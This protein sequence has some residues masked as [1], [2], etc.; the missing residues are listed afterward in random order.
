MTLELSGLA[1]QVRAM[2]QQL[3]VREQEYADLVA[4]ARLWL[5]QY[6]DQGESLCHPARNFHAAI[7][8][9]E[10]L[11]AEHPLPTVPERFTFIAADGT[12]IQPDSHEL[13]YYYLINVGCLVYRH[14]SGQTPEAYSQPTIGYAEDDIYDRGQLVA[15]N[16]LD[17][18][19]DLAEI[20]TLAE[21]CVA[22]S[23]DATTVA[24]VDGTL[25]MWTLAD[26][27]PDYQR[28]KAQVYIQ[29]LDHIRDSGAVVASFISR[30]QRSEV[31]R[32]L[33]L[34]SENGDVER[35]RNSDHRMKRLPDYAVFET[36][37]PGARSALFVSPSPINHAYYASAHTIH[38]FYLNLAAEGSAPAVARI[39]VPSWVAED[40][41]RLALVHGAIV[42]QARIT[43]DYPYALVRADE[44]AFI[45]GPERE[46]LEDMVIASLVRAGVRTALSPKKYY[47]TLTRQGKRKFR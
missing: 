10:P 23:P 43:G 24:V 46:A 16:L 1:E 14:G 38:F 40:A 12:E 2:G 34:A 5:A 9:Q 42:A 4:Q 26:A 8:T 21:R 25:I 35:A 11:D 20:T 7:P 27:S 6:A 39:E 41:D 33:Y 36:L 47:K 22:E 15:G 45:S 28:E 32:L 44:L 31:T 13:A 17:I 29:Q 30:P 18:K 37:A 19:R 3:A